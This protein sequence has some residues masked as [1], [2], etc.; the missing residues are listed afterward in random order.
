MKRYVLYFLLLIVICSCLIRKNKEVFFG[1]IRPIL[2]PEEF[3]DKN[4]IIGSTKVYIMNEPYYL[5]SKDDFVPFIYEKTE[6]TVQNI[7]RER[8]FSSDTVILSEETVKYISD[9]FQNINSFFK[10]NRE[11]SILYDFNCNNQKLNSST[12]A[13]FANYFNKGLEESRHYIDTIFG[14]EFSENIQINFTKTIKFVSIMIEDENI[15]DS[16]L[17]YD[18]DL[19]LRDNKRIELGRL[20]YSIKTKQ[21]E[22]NFNEI[23]LKNLKPI[24]LEYSEINFLVNQADSIDRIDQFMNLIIDSTTNDL[25]LKVECWKDYVKTGKRTSKSTKVIFH[26]NVHNKEVKKISERRYESTIAH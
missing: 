5:E 24:A 8:T 7:I 3:T 21:I 15:W 9:E 6:D 18:Y 14:S 11:G 23:G 10:V 4:F 25:L 19:L 16:T 12:N 22:S 26:I 13:F 20:D 1:V 2:I 17:Y